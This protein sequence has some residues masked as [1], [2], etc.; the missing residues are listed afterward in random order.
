MKFNIEK[1]AMIEIKSR[2]REGAER[3]ELPNQEKIRTLDEKENYK[4]LGILEADTIN[5]DERKTNNKR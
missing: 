1:Y 3:I 4:Y 5:G 2:E